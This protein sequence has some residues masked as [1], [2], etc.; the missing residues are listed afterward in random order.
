MSIT[1]CNFDVEF[2]DEMIYEN[3]VF[4]CFCFMVAKLEI[5][6]ARCQVDKHGFSATNMIIIPLLTD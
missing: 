2:I 5:M 4:F 3:N 1:R 6:F